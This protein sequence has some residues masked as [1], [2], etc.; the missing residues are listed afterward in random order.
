MFFYRYPNYM[1]ALEA[2]DYLDAKNLPTFYNWARKY[3]NQSLF[4][5]EYGEYDVN[6]FKNEELRQMYLLDMAQMNFFFLNIKNSLS[7]LARYMEE[8]TNSNAPTWTSFFSRRLWEIKPVKYPKE[9]S[10]LC[11]W[12]VHSNLLISKIKLRVPKL[13]LEDYLYQ[14]KE[15]E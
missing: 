6:F 3:R 8:N 7:D 13:D 9:P 12:L 10:L 14:K 15:W 2:V 5:N 11:E 1:G 4:K